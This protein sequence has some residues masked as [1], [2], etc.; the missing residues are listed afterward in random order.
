MKCQ[1]SPTDR[2]QPVAGREGGGGAAKGQ[3]LLFFLG[4]HTRSFFRQMVSHITRL[5]WVD[6]EVGKT[7]ASWDW[8]GGQVGG[9]KPTNVVSSR[10]RHMVTTDRAASNHPFYES[11]RIQHQVCLFL[12]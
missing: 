1:D 6:R 8:I 2:K 9:C 5:V 12:K 10:A 4:I 7:G 11:R 3:E